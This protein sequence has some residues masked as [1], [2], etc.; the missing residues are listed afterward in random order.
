M[1]RNSIIP[2]VLLAAAFCAVAATT[3]LKTPSASADALVSRKQAGDTYGVGSM[4]DYGEEPD[5]IKAMA[6]NGAEG[7]VKKTDLLAAE[8]PASSPEDAARKMEERDERLLQAFAAEVNA[9]SAADDINLATAKQLLE[10]RISAVEATAQ[11]IEVAADEDSERLVAAA[12]V[13][14]EQLDD[15]IA[16]AQKRIGTRIPVY[17]VDGTTVIGEFFVG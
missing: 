5:L 3:L 11:G 13:T 17:E 14:V 2:T 1:R 16:S 4:F 10:Y 6:T 9:V 12:G 15:A 8:N 7:Y